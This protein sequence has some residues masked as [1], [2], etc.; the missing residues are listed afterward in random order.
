MMI[1][2][3]SLIGAMAENY[4][5][6]NTV[7]QEIHFRSKKNGARESIEITGS[8][9]ANISF[10]TPNQRIMKPVFTILSLLNLKH[11][12]KLTHMITKVLS[13]IL[14]IFLPLIVCAEKYTLNKEFQTMHY[15]TQALSGKN[16]LLLKKDVWTEVALHPTSGYTEYASFNK[17]SLFKGEEPFCATINMESS[18]YLASNSEV[19]LKTGSPIPLAPAYG[20]QKVKRR[21]LTSLAFILSGI[22]LAAIGITSDE[23]AMAGIGL[24]FI[25]VG[26]TIAISGSF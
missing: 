23:E 1:T 5:S 4:L 21:T 13:A 11:N 3:F 26:C 6:G 25:T 19:L 24:T 8:Y 20:G 18:S 9:E 15:T 14:V 22:P 2:V 17:G 12:L 7:F 10:F 16:Q